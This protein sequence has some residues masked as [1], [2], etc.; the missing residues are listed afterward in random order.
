MQSPSNPEIATRLFI[1]RGTVKTHRAHVYAKLH[2]ANR[3]ELA[4]L[5][6]ARPDGQ[7]VPR[8]ASQVADIARSGNGI[9]LRPVGVQRKVVRPTAW[10]TVGAGLFLAVTAFC[11]IVIV[12]VGS[13]RVGVLLGLL[14][15]ISGAVA[16]RFLMIGVSATADS[17]VVRTLIRTKAVAWPRVR[18]VEVVTGRMRTANGVGLPGHWPALDYVE[19]NGGKRRLVVESLG[20]RRATTAQ[21][22]VADIRELIRVHSGQSH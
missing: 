19:Q 21:R 11:V 16:A 18:G 4:R 13:A 2:I 22:R 12:A 1:S 17:L 7:L 15:V 9:A 6:R 8:G 14:A 10:N 3:T 20:A 5:S